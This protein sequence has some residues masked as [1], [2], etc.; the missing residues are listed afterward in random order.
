[1]HAYRCTEC[2]ETSIVATSCVRCDRPMVFEGEPKPLATSHGFPWSAVLGSIG[3]LIGLAA[4][5]ALLL[6]LHLT[7]LQGGLLHVG[8]PLVGAL[9]GR[10]MGRRRSTAERARTIETEHARWVELARGATSIAQ[11]AEGPVVIRGKVRVVT[12]VHSARAR[13]PCA[14]YVYRQPRSSRDENGGRDFSAEVFDDLSAVGAVEID[15]GSGAVASIDRGP[16]AVVVTMAFV[17]G[18]ARVPDGAR[19]VVRGA[20]RWEVTPSDGD[21]YRSVGRRLVVSG[22]SERPLELWFDDTRQG[23]A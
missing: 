16:C 21:G 12:P 23:G 11:A 9:I 7:I 17:S 22:E 13:V 19:V 5:V 14:A 15:D 18:E 4:S 8:V 6:A 20:A 3:V 2:A 1:M 10:V